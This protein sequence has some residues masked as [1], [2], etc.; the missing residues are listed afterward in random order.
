MPILSTTG[1]G[2][3]VTE[4]V[5]VAVTETPD[6]LVTVSVYVMVLAGLTDTGT[7]DDT[8]PTPL[9]MLPVPLEN[10]AVS[11]V[12]PPA[13]IEELA[14]PKLAMDGALTPGFG[15]P[16]A[17]P[18]LPPPPLHAARTDNS[19]A[20][21]QQRIKLL[22]KHRRS[23]GNRELRWAPWKRVSVIRTHLGQAESKPT[24]SCVP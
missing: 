8:P 21:K 9:L 17:S 3:D 11:V 7:P 19:K 18:L 16:V 20:S 23:R 15:L 10:T 6:E 1:V 22:L 5:V 2:A 4:T 14:A 24:L 12:L 13:V